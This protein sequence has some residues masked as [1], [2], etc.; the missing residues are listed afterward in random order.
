MQIWPAIDLLGGK[1]V[2]LEQGDYD[3]DTVFGDDPAAMARKW[4]DLGARYLHCVDLDGARSGSIVNEEAIRGIV[5]VAAGNAVQ[6]GGGVRNEETIKRLLGLGLSRL[7]VGTSALKD[8]E[9]FA[10][11][12]EKYKGHLVLGLDARDGMVAT[13]GWLK[14]SH[15][16]ATSLITQIQ[17]LTDGVVA[18]VYTDISRDGMLSGPNLEALGAMM[19]V[20]RIPVIASGGVTTIEDID[21]LIAMDVP[22]CIIGRSLYEGQLDLRQV[23]QRAGGRDAQTVS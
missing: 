8:P 10:A 22:G 19:Q 17:Q 14:T 13:Q 16:T 23:L 20:S 4:F 6:L 21:R 18:V 9:W 12:C 2:R 5:N 3:R 7:V 11:M 1:C 15:I